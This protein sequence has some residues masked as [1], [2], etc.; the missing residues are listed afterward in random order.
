MNEYIMNANDKQIA[1]SITVNCREVKVLRIVICV[2]LNTISLQ[3]PRICDQWSCYVFQTIAHIQQTNQK[4]R[5]KFYALITLQTLT[6]GYPE[7]DW[8]NLAKDSD[9]CFDI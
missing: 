4:E 2:W 5:L 7:S 1:Y 8:Q 6:V 3:L 9:Q